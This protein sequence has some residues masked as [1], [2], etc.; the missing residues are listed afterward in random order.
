[1][2]R[3]TMM[4]CAASLLVIALASAAN[5]PAA[6]PP[7]SPIAC[8]AGPGS[9]EPNLTTL[10]DGRV[11]LSWLEPTDTTHLALRCAVYDERP[12]SGVSTV[13]S[14]DSFF[15][16]WADVPSVRPI[17]EHR[18]AAHWLSRGARGPNAHDVRVS[19]SEDGGHSWGTPVI[20]HRDGSAT[21]HGFASLAADSG[22]ALAVWLDGR[23]TEGHDEDAPGPSPDM[24]LRAASVASDGSLHD[25]AEL[26]ARVCDCC[27]TAAVET[28]HGVLV[29]YR[30]RSAEEVRDIY[31]TRLEAG[32]WSKPHAVHADGWHIEGCPVNGPA[33]AARGSHVAI[34]WYTAAADSPR[35]EVAFSDDAGDHF[36]RPTRVDDGDPIGR[37]GIALLADGSAVAVW[38]EASGHDA[39]VRTR[40]ISAAGTPAPAITVAK[41]SS[42]RATGCPRVARSGGTIVFAW[43]EPGTPPRVRFATMSA[44]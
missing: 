29:A 15:V 27:P 7:L 5:R 32:R 3:S 31:V 18:L 22:R 30:D 36:G 28:D 2:K 11:L 23:K 14:G 38:L 40:R 12:W 19:Q 42:G 24:T 10:P 17:G 25:E 43:T 33:L 44:K 9:R 37:A 21:E 4:L 39:L 16:N 6:T 26:D 35:V 8:P 20:P 13:A 1:M 34:A 41:T